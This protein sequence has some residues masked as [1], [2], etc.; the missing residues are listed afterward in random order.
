MA[1][2]ENLIRITLKF[3]ADL[4]TVDKDF[5]KIM[6]NIELQLGELEGVEAEFVTTII[7][8]VVGAGSTKLYLD[9]SE[10]RQQYQELIQ[11]CRNNREAVLE[12]KRRIGV[13]VGFARIRLRILQNNPRFPPPVL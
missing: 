8:A 10:T 4:E 6:E 7:P 2:C 11:K 13:E 9:A 1:H 3:L 12:E 5:D